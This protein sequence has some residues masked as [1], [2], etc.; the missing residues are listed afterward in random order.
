MKIKAIV[1]AVAA[2]AVLD[3]SFPAQCMLS[4]NDISYQRAAAGSPRLDKIEDKKQSTFKTVAEFNRAARQRRMVSGSGENTSCATWRYIPESS[5]HCKCGSSIAKEI[6]CTGVNNTVGVLR[7][8]CITYDSSDQFLLTG[9]CLYS[10]F[11]SDGY[12]S[13]YNV[14][15]DPSQLHKVCKKYS[16]MGQLCG[17]C[18]DSFAPPIYS[19]NLSCVNCT[20][21][22]NSNGLK[23]LAVSFIP[24][25]GFFFFIIMCRISVTSGLLNAFILIVQ[26]LTSP[27]LMR[28]VV[29]MRDH[30]S[31]L[32]LI[33][34]ASVFGIWN[35]DFFRLVYSSF[36]LHPKMTMLQ[37][38]AM[39]Y[40]IAV[41]PL[42]LIV[43]T[44]AL[45]ELHDYFRVFNSLWKPFRWLF[46][47]IRRQW[48]VRISLIEAFATFLLLSYVKFLNVSFDILNPMKV[49]NVSGQSVGIYVFYNGTV[50]FL[51]PAHRP[52][53]I[54]ALIVLLI[55]N[56]FPIILLSVYPCR[57]FQRSLARCN[58]RSHALHI[59]MDAF[60]GCY[61]NGTS[62]TRDCR[63]FS[64]TYLWVRFVFLIVG[65]ITS[66]AISLCIGATM[67]IIVA[68]MVAV[69]QPYKS[70][71]YNIVDTALIHALAFMF[72]SGTANSIAYN[73]N[74]QFKGLANTM[75]CISFLIP[76][77]YF[78]GVVVYKLFSRR[79][80][81]QI[82]ETIQLCLLCRCKSADAY[83]EGSL[84][85]RIE[86]P[87]QY[88][89]MFTESAAEGNDGN[90]SNYRTPTERTFLL[91]F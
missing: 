52:Y 57:C 38:I 33:V 77:A 15:P 51:S 70:H 2:L 37:V 63:W 69:V 91:G 58:L 13:Y 28:F 30:R 46:G 53:A 29:Q 83:L 34:L 55:F 82:Y 78:V 72:I 60:Q 62:G 59:F 20:R 54:L 43:V 18:I 16:R 50:S 12:Q 1:S 71:A 81:T 24:L 65:S 3:A 86:H 87:E 23:F 25:T 42:A 6:S 68:L 7:C 89:A 75:V 67:S 22:H 14:S 49:H 4:D 31:Q 79:K 66:T 73:I 17:K 8:Y 45:V 84:P 88:V 36:C 35:L 80:W 10:C 9:G 76:F 40:V 56:V 48:N 61:K 90:E 32:P 44:Y 64:T 21:Y 11:E 85:D 41:Y 27:L 47:H 39:D 19:Y 74:I 26:L 5:S